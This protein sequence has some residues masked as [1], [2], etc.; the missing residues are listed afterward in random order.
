MKPMAAASVAV[1]AKLGGHDVISIGSSAFEYCSMTSLSLPSGLMA[2]GEYAFLSCKNLAAVSFPDSLLMIGKQAFYDCDALTSVN[3]NK[4]GV[5]LGDNAFAQCDKI[6]TVKFPDAIY[7]DGLGTGVFSN[8][9]S[10]ESATM[11]A[12]ALSAISEKQ[13]FKNCPS[14]AKLSYVGKTTVDGV[15][16]AYV[17]ID[18]EG[19][20]IGNGTSCAIDAT[21]T[22]SVTIPSMIEIGGGSYPVKKIAARAFHQCKMSSVT[23]PSSVTAVDWEAFSSSSIT[24]VTVPSSVR[25]LGAG[26]F[27]NCKSLKTVTL[28]SGISSI[29]ARAFRYC[30]KLASVGYINNANAVTS[31]GDN[32]FNGCAALT[33]FTTTRSFTSLG[34]GAFK[35]CTSLNFIT[36]PYDVFYPELYTNSELRDNIFANCQ[37][38]EISFL[39]SDSSSP[40]RVSLIGGPYTAW[41]V[42]AYSVVNN[43]ARLG[44]IPP[45]IPCTL[46]VA[47]GGLFTIPERLGGYL[48]TE[49]GEA[50]FK[51]CTGLTG[52]MVPDAVTRI[53]P[54]AFE[55]C[56]ALLGVKLPANLTTIDDSAFK[57]CTAFTVVNVPDKVTSV[58]AN[59][60][61]GCSNLTKVTLPKSMWHS[62]SFTG[63][64]AN[65]ATAYRWDDGAYREWVNDAGW[66]YTVSG[67][68]ATVTGG[69]SVVF[70]ATMPSKLGG[71]SVTAIADNAFSDNSST[72]SMLRTIVLPDTL[73]T[74]GANAFKD[75]VKLESITLPDSVTSIGAGVFSGCSAMEAA[76]LNGNIT[77]IPANAFKDCSSL[78]GVYFNYNVVSIGDSAFSGCSSLQWT[79]PNL[80]TAKIASI[81]KYAFAGCTSDFFNDIILGDSVTTIGDY[82]FINCNYNLRAISLPGSLSGVID[83]SK[84][85]RDCYNISV[86]YRFADGEFA[87]TINGIVWRYKFTDGN[88]KAA[89]LGVTIPTGKS[90]R[91]SAPAT[92]GGKTVT[93]IAENAFKDNLRISGFNV[94]ASSSITAIGAAAFSGCY[95]LETLSLGPVTT[96]GGNAFAGCPKLTAVVLDN[97]THVG[98]GAFENCTGLTY[99]T[100]PDGI[101]DFG[102]SAFEG[103]TGLVTA[104][105]P[106]R[107]Y[108]G[109]AIEN[110][111]EGCPESLVVT[112]RFASGAVKVQKI[113]K[114]KWTMKGT[115]LFSVDNTY[116]AISPKPMGSVEI[117]AQACGST[118]KTIGAY[119]FAGCTSMTKVTIPVGVTKIEEHAFDGCTRLSEVA[120][121]STLTSIG[122]YAFKDCTKLTAVD[123]PDYLQGK[124]NTSVVFNGYSPTITYYTKGGIKTETFE[125][126]KWYYRINDGEAEIY[127]NDKVAVENPPTSGML[128]IPTTLGGK[129]VT[130]IGKNA[131][132][133]D[134]NYVGG[135]FSSVFIPDTVTSIGESAFQSCH[136]LSNVYGG[137]GLKD[138]EKYAFASCTSLANLPLKEGARSLGLS[139]F[140]RTAVTSV[141]LP[142]TLTSIYGC[143]FDSC[144]NLTE[145]SIPAS[146]DDVISDENCRVFYYSTAIENVTLS[147]D[148]QVE[149]FKQILPY[150][151]VKHV[152]LA[153]GVTSIAANSFTDYIGTEAT[154]NYVRLESIT[155]PTSLKSIGARAFKRS[156]YLKNVEIPAGVTSIGAEAFYQC[157]ALESVNIP[158]GLTDVGNYAFCY[159]VNLTSVT[160]EPGLTAIGATGVFSTCTGL[161]SVTIPEGVTSIAESAFDHCSALATV[162]I[163]QS[164]ETIGEKAFRSAGLATVHVAARDTDRVKAL[165]VA[166]GLTQEFVDGLDFIEPA[167]DYYY[168]TFD[169]NGGT[170]SASVYERA[171]NANLG[172]LPT[173]ERAN[174]SF[175]GWF[176]EAE[177][178]TKIG[179]TKKVT[180]NITYYAHWSLNQH[181]V[182]IDTGT[183]S[184]TSVPIDHGTTIGDVLLTI[185]QP[186]R[187]GYTFKGWVD[188]DDEPLD[189]LA[190]VTADTTFIA[191][192]AKNVV[193][194]C[195]AV[196]DGELQSKSAWYL[197]VDGVE[198]DVLDIGSQFIDSYVFQ[199]WSAEPAG[200]LLTG[201]IIAAEGL[202]LYA[203]FTLDAWTVTFDANGGD[204]DTISV[205]VAKG[206]KLESL[207][208]ATR[209]GFVQNGWWTAADGGDQIAANWTEITGDIT[210]YAHWTPVATVDGYAYTY[211][212]EDGKATI[213]DD[214]G[215]VAVSPWPTGVYE[216]PAMLNG[217]PV[218]KIGHGAFALVS[219]TEVVIPDGVTEIGSG[220]FNMCQSLTTVTLPKSVTTIGISA[221]GGCDA[222]ATFNVEYGDTSRV[223]AMLVASGLDQAFVNGLTFV[224]AEAPKFTVTLDPNG[225]S[226]DPTS[227]EVAEGAK[228]SALLPTPA[229]PGFS[230]TGWFT[231]AEGGEKVTAETTATADVTYFAQWTAL[232]AYT[233]TLDANG[234]T[235]ALDNILVYA[236]EKIGDL[237][238]PEKEGFRFTAWK[239]GST[240]VTKDTVVNAD[241]TIVAQWEEIYVPSEFTVT[242]DVNGGTLASGSAS[243]TVTEGQKVGTKLP[244]ATRT[245]YEFTGWKVSDLLWVDADTVV[246]ENLACTAQWQP[247]TY[248]VTYN[249]NGGTIGG[250][251][252]MTIDVFY[253][254]AYSLPTPDE[255]VGWTFAGW[256]TKATGG[257]QVKDGDTVTITAAQTLFAH[258]TEVVV[259]KYTVTFN[260]NGGSVSPASV[261]VDEGSAIGTA[262][263]SLPTPTWDAD[264]EF[265]GW[266]LGVDLATTATIVTSDIELFALWQEAT[267]G[268]GTWTDP[269]TSI[270][271]YYRSATDGIG[272]EL[273]RDTEAYPGDLQAV[274]PKPTGVLTIP[275][276]IDGKPVTGI[277]EYAF[278]NC[279]EMT[280]VKIP[281]TVTYIGERAF[282]LAGLTE[283]ELPA[284]LTTIGNGAFYGCYDLTS[285][286]IPSGVTSIGED[287]FMNNINLTEVT[288]PSSVTEIGTNA[289]K[290]API[291]TLHVEEGTSADVLQLI[292]DSGFDTTQITDVKEDAGSAATTYTVTFDAQGGRCT[293]GETTRTVAAGDKV[294]ELPNV[295]LSGYNFLGW[296]TTIDGG[297]DVDANTVVTGNVTYY[298]QLEG[299]PVTVVLDANGG[300]FT[301]GNETSF[302]FSSRY[303]QPYGEN[304]RT[305]TDEGRT[306]VGWFTS[307]GVQVTADTLIT[308]YS[309]TLTAHWTEGGGGGGGETTYGTEVVDGYTYSYEVVDGKATIWKGDPSLHYRIGWVAIDPLPVGELEIP[310]TLGGYPVVGIGYLAFVNCRELTEV[311][312]PNSVTTIEESAFAGCAALKRI[313]IPASVTSIGASAF[314]TTSLKVVHTGSASEKERV[315]DMIAASGGVSVDSIA[316]I[317]TTG[318]HYTVTFGSVTREYYAGEPICLFPEVTRNGYTLNAWYDSYVLRNRVTED[319]VITEATTFYARWTQTEELLTAE[320]NG[321]VWSYKLDGKN[322][323]IYN[324]GNAA[325]SPAPEGHIDV[326]AK[327]GNANVVQIGDYAFYGCDA[328]TSVKIPD[329]VKVVG[330]QA[331]TYCEA[332]ECVDAGKNLATI[333]ASAFGD[334]SVLAAV[335]FRGT[336]APVADTL[337]D[338]LFDGSTPAEC[339]LYVN[340]SAK[341][342]PMTSWQGQP[343]VR[344]DYMV[345][346]P[347]S[348]VEGKSAYCKSL[349]GAGQY[350][351]GKKV[352][353]KATENKGY[354]F[355][356]WYDKDGELV[357]RT[358]SYAFTVTGE[359]VEFYA[360]FVTVQEDEEALALYLDEVGLST[361][362]DGSFQD[363]IMDFMFSYSEPKLS[364]KGLPPGLKFDAKTYKITGKATK[365]GIYTVTASLSNKTVKK[366]LTA[367][368]TIY[369][370]NFTDELLPLE[371]QYGEYVPGVEYVVPFPDAEGWAVSGLPSGMKWTTKEVLDTKTK[372]LKAPA[373]SVYGAATKPGNYTVYFTKTV[374]KV[375]HTVTATFVVSAFPVLTVNYDGSGLG[376]VTGFGSYPANK[377]V[378]LKAS[379]IGDSVFQGWYTDGGIP[380]SQAASYS[381]VMPGEDTTLYAYFITRA[382][383]MA[384]IMFDFNEGEAVFDG[385]SS[386]TTYEKTIPCGVYVQWPLMVEALSLPTVKVSGLPSGLK[387]TAKDI[388]KKGSTTEVEI[389]ANTIYGTPTAAS[390]AGKPSVIKITITTAGKTKVEY[391]F[392]TTVTAMEDW[393]VG[394]FSGGG[395]N[396][397]LTLTVAASG[398]ISGKY[399]A[400]GLTWTLSAANFTDYAEGAEY[401]GYVTGKSGK[402]EFTERLI[403][404]RMDYGLG[405]AYIGSDDFLGFL[406]QTKWKE[407]PWKSVAKTFAGER[408]LAVEDKEGRPG[409]L[410]FKFAS[411]GA[412]TIK[413]EFT[414]LDG[415]TYSASASADLAPTTALESTGFEALVH[416]YFPPKA[417]KFSGFTKSVIV[418][419]NRSTGFNIPEQ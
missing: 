99:V 46:P 64:P 262:I 324:N 379:P 403:V 304:L 391:T 417:G 106:S 256:F 288:I 51:G 271:W 194:D 215:L 252:S 339:T 230:F 95:N 69:S 72:K 213:Y 405:F 249:A 186:T 313:T 222:L 361:Y 2:I 182:T 336:K 317:D 169:A 177:G 352:T 253:D 311:T 68:E 369:V 146:L 355:A 366:A 114:F 150:R 408:T 91:L 1:P 326:P 92:L 181:T 188:A 371:D 384:G 365:P 174:H 211:K 314:Q 85:F 210:A 22:G 87:E 338:D 349:T 53:G 73:K 255:R 76:I 290:D 233:V 113:G 410:T 176:T 9:A 3:L 328:M 103:C 299:V 142:S 278:Y 344:G 195:Y 78:E 254:G 89:I 161:A 56:T 82:A 407:E 283:I 368:F 319:F 118:V 160:F 232:T 131:F 287:A 418:E 277:G 320:A 318:P 205:K 179:P 12:S 219:I 400:D 129:P 201:T 192:W 96:I 359:Q 378:S 387:F 157:S 377:K 42:W 357:S 123:M 216:I 337:K 263:A 109:F 147:T 133:D 70:D 303:G 108:A 206:E 149:L 36:L 130:R 363:D 354:V 35:N 119:A 266:Y 18:G 145:V 107:F 41:T 225:G 223:K 375:K 261:Q 242:F 245:G 138:F 162:T 94:P 175:L 80:T 270:T 343:I 388:Y 248:A 275:D 335:Q 23:I 66:T 58:A 43:T 40:E 166:S 362:E 152:T 97:V 30:D 268:G 372:E 386:T 140:A 329:S 207:P 25:T 212:V 227:V 151:N 345:S 6:K 414:G 170:A 90:G 280:G 285:V 180:G 376:K 59:A 246:T 202:T 353:L 412:V 67:N 74:I 120:F 84:V 356:G 29:P 200:E 16:M 291:T 300:V 397:M 135:E 178:G 167:P 331:F 393:A 273:Y 301:P 264:H 308:Q 250:V 158:A 295:I 259:T 155:L 172:T 20:Q 406:Y 191:V 323:V 327:L 398:K 79:F 217:V 340:K 310:A 173:A 322:A 136:N 244:S 272:V 382:E 370:M 279:T 105:L 292:A 193:V 185:T 122:D 5:I 88:S 112:F 243:I 197:G 309:H 358:A 334:C 32:A 307:G 128:N 395:D 17:Y 351:L 208:E 409:M 289:F 50:A 21:K 321:Y 214:R 276:T 7:A 385:S 63:C 61:S 360:D 125:S 143:P 404:Q 11:P 187:E 315:R 100:V 234:G 342:W 34:N 31:I 251:E 241:M 86:T 347:A 153:E 111:F 274:S 77:V 124:I 115:T 148:K 394:T 4:A 221:F 228:V 28:G 281:D 62:A 19:L 189:L 399:L 364:F 240:T 55:G 48:V 374:N 239:Q 165:L 27:E 413:G 293:S 71:Y 8:C 10:L 341:D 265:L 348:V 154:A 218:G 297:V 65:M 139:A 226:V 389:P 238:T 183:G 260:A 116:N 380:L 269:D 392:V 286:E 411:S 190:P 184:T 110:W 257:E 164:V 49:I 209:L 44:S 156:D 306:F 134:Y 14:T 302:M 330:N 282:G 224:E 396:S 373:N 229:Y 267:A 121:P 284:G 33:R 127:N 52:I 132:Y 137:D 83:E 235:V 258:W 333:G 198:G 231:A 401:V 381:Y 220:A 13:V 332:L 102:Y 316:F 126:R 117:P 144:P 141:T 419:W 237:P 247:N 312:I 98:E 26:V 325:V 171:P 15:E 45:T 298:A 236:G 39:P 159:C 163:P 196:L 47:A 346:V 203:Q 204:C 296:G 390:K 57:G 415:K 81:G 24:S 38:L 199:G 104:S 402:A 367:T 93:S 416:V 350:A 294:G 305:P 60:F 168:I 75:C 37:L 54:N 383:D 101:V